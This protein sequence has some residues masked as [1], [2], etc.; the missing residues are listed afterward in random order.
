MAEAPALAEAWGQ[1]PEPLSPS[2]DCLYL[3]PLK[4]QLRRLGSKGRFPRADPGKLAF[5]RL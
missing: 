2:P 1:P 4:M 5:E 3:G